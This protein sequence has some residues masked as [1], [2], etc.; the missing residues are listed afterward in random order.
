MPVSINSK[1]D[2]QREGNCQKLNKT[3]KLAKIEAKAK[4]RTIN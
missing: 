3:R 1:G 2:N 4:Q